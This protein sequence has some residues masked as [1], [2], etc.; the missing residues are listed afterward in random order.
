MIFGDRKKLATIMS[1]K[2]G[3]QSMAPLKAEHESNPDKQAL[4]VIAQDIIA[5]VESKS[6]SDLASGLKAFFA[7]C[8]AEEDSYEE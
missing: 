8:E 6:A 7:S 4:H 2:V 1:G 5:A 3:S